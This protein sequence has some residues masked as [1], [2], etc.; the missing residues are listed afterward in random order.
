MSSP[1]KTLVAMSGGVD[2]SVAALLLKEAGHEITGIFICLGFATDAD[3]TS[4]ACC[5]PQDAADARRVAQAL[6]MELFVLNVGNAFDAIIADFASEYAAGRTPNPCIHCNTHIKFGRLLAHA[7]SLGYDRVA[8]GHYARCIMHN[9]EARLARAYNV[10]KDQ[11]YV[12]FELG[13]DERRRI[14]FPLGEIT[15]KEEVRNHARRLSLGVSEKP[16]SQEICFVEGSD[17]APVLQSRAPE[18]LRHGPIVDTAG[19][20]VGH[21]DGYAR[22]TIGQRRGLNVAVGERVY[23]TGINPHNA[24]ITIGNHAATLSEGLMAQRAIWHTETPE[25]FEA[26]VQ[27]RYNHRGAKALVKRLDADRFQVTF[28]EPV[29][30]VTPGQAAVLYQDDVIVGGGW[31]EAALRTV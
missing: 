20:I 26:M 23:V 17:Y 24:T 11:S 5:T 12:L 21:H 15:N 6:G 1:G 22:F 28:A 14:T 27:I 30:A 9:G 10:A 29:H 18:A 19:K 4:R 3:T 8:T 13:A 2:S 31:I 25:Q 7:K 16:D